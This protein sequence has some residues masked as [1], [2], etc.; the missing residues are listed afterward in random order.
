M[1]KFEYLELG[2]NQAFQ[3]VTMAQLQRA[4]DQNRTILQQNQGSFTDFATPN[5]NLIKQSVLGGPTS[6]ENYELQPGSLLSNQFG[7]SW[8]EIVDKTSS[9][10]H[11]TSE[12][13]TFRS[14]RRNHCENMHHT[15]GFAF[16]QFYFSFLV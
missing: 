15:V 9:L 16:K 13:D 8:F 7:Y 5:F 12:K 6:Q 4:A 2:C 3:H 10:I 11:S 14:V 1:R